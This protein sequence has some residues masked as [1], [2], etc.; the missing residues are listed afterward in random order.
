MSVIAGQAYT[1][2][3]RGVDVKAELTRT[4]ARLDVFN[5]T[6]NMK[7]TDVEITNAV[8]K[9]Y[10]FKGDVTNNVHQPADAGKITLKPMLDMVDKLKAGIVYQTPGKP[11]EDSARV[12]NVYRMA[13]LYEQ[14][15]TDDATSPKVTIHYEL[16]VGNGQTNTQK[17]GQVTVPFKRTTQ[18]ADYVDVKRNYIY[19]IKLGDGSKVATGVV[20]VQFN[21]VDWQKGTDIDSD[22]NVNSQK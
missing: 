3:P 16:T 14:D 15:V 7:I 6:P 20:D 9:S 11:I 5:Y 8:D 4:V 17:A 19:T 12:K 2:T 18:T 10:L 13:Y 21:V 1:L 22:L